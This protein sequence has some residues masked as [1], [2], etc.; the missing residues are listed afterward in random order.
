MSISMISSKKY[1]L[2]ALLGFIFLVLLGLSSYFFFFNKKEVVLWDFVPS[3]SIAVYE[4]DHLDRDSWNKYKASTFWKNILLVEESSKI[5]SK[6][7]EGLQEID[8]NNLVSN[9]KFY[10]ST[11]KLTSDNLGFVFYFQLPKSTVSKMESY[12]QEMEDG[13]NVK[14][15]KRRYEEFTI[16]DLAFD[17]KNNTKTFSYIIRENV[18]IASFS[19]FLLEDAVRA[20]S[21]KLKSFKS[22]HDKERRFVEQVSDRSNLYVNMQKINEFLSCFVNYPSQLVTNF[23]DFA[24]VDLRVSNQRMFGNG[25]LKVE[26]S[27]LAALKGQKKTKFGFADLVSTRSSSLFR[28]GV[29]DFELFHSKL[30]K[31]GQVPAIKDDLSWFGEELGITKTEGESHREQI[32]TLYLQ[33]KDRKLAEKYFSAFSVDNDFSQQFHDT[34][35]VQMS[36]SNLPEK[37]FGPPFKGFEIVYY[38]YVK[39]YILI[40]PDFGVLKDNLVDIYNEDTWGKRIRMNNFFRQLSSK[41]NLLYVVNMGMAWTALE[42]EL[43]NPRSIYKSILEQFQYLAFDLSHYKKDIFSISMVIEA[44]KQNKLYKKKKVYDNLVDLELPSKLIGEISVFANRKKNTQTIMFQDSTF[45]LY[46]LDNKG[47]VLWEVSLEEPIIG[48]VKQIDYYKKGTK[49]FVFTTAHSFYVLDNN[50][51]NISGFPFRYKHISPIEYFSIFDYDNTKDY[52][53]CLADTDGNVWLYDK[54]KNNLKGWKPLRIGKALEQE[55]KH[56]RVG[57]KDYVL[58][59]LENGT[60]SL[61]NRRGSRADGFPLKLA[62]QLAQKTFLKLGR[63]AKDTKFYALSEN[64]KLVCANFEGK[65]LTTTQLEKESKSDEFFLFPDELNRTFLIGRFSKDKLTLYDS[66]AKVLFEKIDFKSKNTIVQYYRFDAK[67]QVI[68]VVNTLQG[69]AYLFDKKGKLINDF[70]LLGDKKI[71]LM[72]FSKKNKYRVFHSLSDQFLITEF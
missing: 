1:L 20:F 45:S 43:K 64:G 18:I 27:Y 59:V 32:P 70:P 15:E 47:A 53:F 37:C 63:N 33:V 57:T 68:S 28:I 72:Y 48:K 3:S 55:V 51:K 31:A 46:C 54:N 65:V 23:A 49:N 34:E 17:G 67:N 38:A 56:T 5:E 8:E 11:H 14:Y 71:G 35:I 58:T 9:S 36:L 66:N 42:D 4:I 62:N 21:G 22:E 2:L 13:D 29:S 39:D 61:H 19:A 41:N 50:G 52:R 30:R 24:S 7:A 6:I 25:I 44:D 60:I 40:C 12:L 69:F 26:D 16:H 10:I